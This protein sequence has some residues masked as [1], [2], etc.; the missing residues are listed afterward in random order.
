MAQPIPDPERVLVVNADAR[1]RAA[2]AALIDA[3][4]GLCV[5]ATTSSIGDAGRLASAFRASVAVVDA[6]AGEPDDLAVMGQLATHLPVVATCDVA[7]NGG[8]ALAAGAM[9]T[10]DK[11][12]DPDDLLAAVAAA[13]RQRRPRGRP[14]LD[15]DHTDSTRRGR[16]G[17]S[18]RRAGAARGL[19][20]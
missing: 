8:R 1:V 2:L 19:D 7:S 12:G 14:M 3:T 18:A 4:P 13:A 5:A 20:T 10:C 6:D 11:N 17:D 16:R 9:A 15:R